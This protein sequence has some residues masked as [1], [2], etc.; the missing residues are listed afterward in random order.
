[1]VISL[2]SALSSMTYPQGATI[3]NKLTNITSA[4]VFAWQ[5][6]TI[7]LIVLNLTVW[8]YVVEIRSLSEYSDY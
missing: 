6:S 8:P 2:N 4:R 3:G 1:M 7:L 5:S